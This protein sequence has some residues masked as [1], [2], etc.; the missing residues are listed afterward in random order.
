[1]AGDSVPP[2]FVRFHVGNAHV[3]SRESLAAAIREAITA[4]SLYEYGARHPRARRFS[5][6]GVVYAAPLPSGDAA[7]IRHSRRG[8]AFAP[9]TR[10]LFL[11]PT[12]AEH[13]LR[14]SERLRA[15]GIATPEVL[16]V[17]VYPV[18]AIL[19]RA[20]VVTREISNAFDLAVALMSDDAAMRASAL[21]ATAS[22]VAAL[23]DVAAHHPDLNV[24]NV[25]LQPGQN[26]RPAGYVLDVD[27]IRFVNER[28][29][30]L[31]RNVARLVRSARKWQSVN[32][33]RV[34]AEELSDFAAACQ[35]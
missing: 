29:R 16:A 1:M 23:S 5:G 14:T 18:A 33:A 26:G 27:R 4:G 25:L 3:V 13:E 2:G 19:R 9:I 10:D 34:T 11:P 24:K 31:N 15:A 35:R 28:S 21:N 6:R 8:G 22:L 7:V 30:A 32:G 20:D 12:R 17:A